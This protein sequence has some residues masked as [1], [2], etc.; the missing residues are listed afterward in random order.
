MGSSY[1]K[2]RK[3]PEQWEDYIRAEEIVQSPEEV[4]RLVC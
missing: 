1:L 2:Y 3:K 4:C